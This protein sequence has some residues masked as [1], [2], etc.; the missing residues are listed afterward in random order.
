[1]PGTPPGLKEYQDHAQDDAQDDAQD[2]AQDDDVGQRAGVHCQGRAVYAVSAENEDP[3][4]T[5]TSPP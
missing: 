5:K 2:H 3:S 4:D 1:M